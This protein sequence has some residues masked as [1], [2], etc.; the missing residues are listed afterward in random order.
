MTVGELLDVYLDGL[1]ADRQLSA[2]TRF[3]YRHYADN[4]VRPHL[5]AKKVRDLTPDA[6]VAWQRLLAKQGG[7]KTG[8]AL[9]PNTIRLARC[10][11]NGALKLAVEMGVIGTNATARV[12]HRVPLG[13]AFVRTSERH[14]LTTPA[15]DEPAFDEQVAKGGLLWAAVRGEAGPPRQ[16]HHRWNEAEEA[17]GRSHASAV[18]AV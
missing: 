3:D 16:R 5:G 4:Y 6:V 15:E 12:P 2:K 9:S 8:K 10:P 14:D 13:S 1:D 18:A 11:L 7:T 17:A